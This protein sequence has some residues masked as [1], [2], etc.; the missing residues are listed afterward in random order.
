MLY[1]SSYA[2]E[3]DTSIDSE[4]RKKYNVEELNEQNADKIKLPK[5]PDLPS[6]DISTVPNLPKTPQKA[7]SYTTLSANY[8]GATKTLKSGTRFLVANSKKLADSLPKGTVIT[9]YS[10]ESVERNGITIPQGTAFRGKIVSSHTPQ[11]TGNGGL[12]GIE[13]DGIIYNKTLSKTSAVISKANDKRVF[14][15]KIKGKRQYWKNVKKA[16]NFGIKTNKKWSEQQE[17]LK[18]ILLSDC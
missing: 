11:I 5:L 15:G 16:N 8:S 2:Y 18:N 4:I 12:I 14:N 7:E 9:F 6:D 13:I 1:S 10:L 3:L 17:K